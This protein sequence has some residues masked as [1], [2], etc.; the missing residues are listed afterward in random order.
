MKTILHF[1]RLVLAANLVLIKLATA[2]LAQEVIIP[3]PGLNAAVRETLG[4]PAGPLTQQD[5]LGLTNLS[6]ISSNI[7]NLMGL[8][9]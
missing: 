5:L 3:D 1:A 6:A 4:I 8:E 9:A 7:T 2:S